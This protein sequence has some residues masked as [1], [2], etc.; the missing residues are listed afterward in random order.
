MTKKRKANGEIAKHKSEKGSSN[1]IGDGQMRHVVASHRGTGTEK[2][3]IRT[4]SNVA[5]HVGVQVLRDIHKRDG[6]ALCHRETRRGAHMLASGAAKSKS[7]ANKGRAG[8]EGANESV[9]D[10]GP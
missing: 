8:G 2:P 3:K 9:H 6:R 4:K 5:G 1:I 10:D 7:T